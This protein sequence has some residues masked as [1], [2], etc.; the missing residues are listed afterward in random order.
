MKKEL[1]G[2]ATPE[3]IEIWKKKVQADYGASHKVYKYEVD[4]R[5]CYLRS[6]DR[7]TYSLAS[8]KVSTSP[9]KFGD[10]V[11]ERIWLGGDAT[12]KNEDGYYFG[13]SEFVDKLMDKKV[14]ELGEL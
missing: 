2:Q 6:V 7:D 12:I 9:A 13:L 11:I 5:V 10:T 4:D 3:Q 1:I 8:S 14:G